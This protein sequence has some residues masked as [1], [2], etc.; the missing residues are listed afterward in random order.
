MC[1]HVKLYF[2]IPIDGTEE[3]DVESVWALPLEHGYKLDNIP[4]YA[5]GVSFGDVVGAE[6]IDGCLYVTNLIEPSGHSTVRIWFSD[7][8]DVLETR[9]KLES[10]GCSSEIS[11][12]SRLIAVDIP[13]AVGYEDVRRYFEVGEEHGKWDFEEAC[14]GFL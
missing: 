3:C 5:T 11:D 6:N 10:L 13:P 8:S 12:Q 2:E 4:F 1:K 7:L 14:L 9:K